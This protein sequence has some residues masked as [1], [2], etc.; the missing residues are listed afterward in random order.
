MFKRM[1]GVVAAVAVAGAIG[2][3]GANYYNKSKNK[4][5]D[6]SNTTSD[7]VKEE[8]DNNSSSDSSTQSEVN[9]EFVSEDVMVEST[10]SYRNDSG[11]ILGSFFIVVGLTSVFVCFKN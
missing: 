1:L 7:T 9:E 3:A 2:I 10:S 6:F 8:V 11:L 4:S 5:D